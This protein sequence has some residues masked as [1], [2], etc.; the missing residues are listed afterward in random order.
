[1]EF[2]IQTWNTFLN[3]VKT[4]TVFDALDVIVVSFIIY[5]GIKLVRE[6]RAGQLVK[7]IIILLLLWAL[8]GYFKLYML[9]TA[10]GFFFEYGVIALLIVFQ[11]ELRR[12]IEQIGREQ[13][14]KRKTFLA[15]SRFSKRG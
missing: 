3:L 1:M 11:P 6:T 4:F 2:V 15:F 8:S 13:A 9:K 5:N 10:L 14:W 7:G 12:I